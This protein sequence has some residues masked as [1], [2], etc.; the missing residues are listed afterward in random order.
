MSESFP[1]QYARTQRFTL[2]E[3]RDV[4]V[5]PDGA[6]VVFLRSSAGD[7]PVNALWVFDVATG[8]ERRVADPRELLGVD[9]PS[10]V[11][12]T[13]AERARRERARDGTSGITG[14][15]TDESCRF[16]TFAVNGELFTAD[17]VEGAAQHLP[18]DGPVHDPRPAP[19]SERIA[20][21]GG[22]SLR[23][24][25]LDGTSRVLAG[26]GDPDG[27][28][29]WGG[30][31]FIAA[32][33]MHRMRGYWWS[34]DG[35][36]IAA[37]R[38]DDEPVSELTIADPANPDRPPRTV[39]YP[40]AGSDN[41][42]VS[43]HLL[44]LDGSRCEVDWDREAFPYLAVV[45]WSQHGLLISTQSRDQRRTSTMTVDPA[46]GSVTEVAS[47]DDESWV[48]NVPGVPRLVG[49]G[50]VLTA[51][52]RDGMRRLF[53]DGAAVTPTELQ[54]R[55]VANATEDEIIFLANELEDPTELHIWSS[56]R[57]RVTDAPGSHTAAIGG[58]TMVV[59][60]AD[61]S[62]PGARHA[63]RVD[64]AVDGSL[65]A[66]HAETPSIV[67]NVTLL[68]AGERSLATAVLLP[69]GRD[70]DDDTPLPVLLDP[71]G[72]PHAQRVTSVHNAHLSS[73][74]FA[75]QGYAVVVSDGRGTPGR[76]A[77]WE[78]SVRD[79]LANPPLDDQIDALHATAEEFPM[80]D[81]DRVAIRGWSF[82]GYLAALAVLRR[83]D[84]FHAAIAGAPVT[85]WR[86]YDTH[87]TERY[88][89][90]PNTDEGAAVYDANSL[91]PLAG[92]LRRPLL[93][94]HGLA[95]D[96]VVAAH[97]LQLSSALLAA[98][99][100]HE[101]LPL[102]GVTHMTPQEVVAENLL[103]HQLDF[104]ARSLGPDLETSTT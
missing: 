75:D 58:A 12:L 82:G 51:S 49:G 22:S 53:V 73:Q 80:L 93:L 2:G 65:L 76:G 35:Q 68:R 70:R 64:G 14:Y 78:R 34:P 103:R 11:E 47:D 33:E 91:L 54:V 46:T 19:T 89:G 101:V 30:A 27:N 83:P 44:G 13:D 5:S 77:A 38:V 43:L 86:L 37:C 40:L 6:R 74:W 57:G 45:E 66:S 69:T 92:D 41:P 72:G 67:P 85:E 96:N 50:R 79:D 17:L 59:R 63:V 52:D 90:D 95:D 97:T 32:E 99:R 3:P 10:T 1:R 81:L 71:Y 42:T 7:D 15:A 88:L 102:V 87:Y 61:L 94:I 18:V 62:L 28:V 84:V 39:R 21:V 48:E 20:Y 36:S 60:S 8:E 98:G 4:R 9:D 55:A 31:D 56:T 24:A 29:S 16:A 104:L 23:V 26:P 100:P 25:E